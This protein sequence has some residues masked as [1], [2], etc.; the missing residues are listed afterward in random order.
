MN[1]DNNTSINLA[2]YLYINWSI[3]L[4][5]LCTKCT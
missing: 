3:C 1:T 4:N 5:V 2:N